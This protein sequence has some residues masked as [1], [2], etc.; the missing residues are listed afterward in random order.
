M[1]SILMERCC[2]SRGLSCYDL[3]Q[4]FFGGRNKSMSI[5]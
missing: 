5:L 2:V 1:V 4:S 3:E